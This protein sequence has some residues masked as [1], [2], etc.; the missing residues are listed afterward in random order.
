MNINFFPPLQLIAFARIAQGILYTFDLEFLKRNFMLGG[1]VYPVYTQRIQQKVSVIVLRHYLIRFLQPSGTPGKIDQVKH[2]NLP[3][4]MQKQLVGIVSALGFEIVNWFEF[5]KGIMLQADHD[6]RN[7]LSWFS[8]GIIDRFETARNFILD[9]K[10]SVF[11]RFHLACKYYFEDYAPL[12]F[13]RIPTE[14][15]SSFLGRLSDT[16][17][18]EL[19]SVVL[20]RHA[21]LDWG[22]ISRYERRHFFRDNFLGIRYYFKRL[23]GLE[24]RCQCLFFALGNEELHPL[25]LYLCLSQM[26]ANEL[27]SLLSRLP[28]RALFDL[29][30]YF[31]CWPFQII[32]MNVVNNFKH[33][34]DRNTFRNLV[35]SILYKLQKGWYDYRYVNLFESLWSLMSVRYGRFF[36]EDEELK[37]VADFALANFV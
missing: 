5:H 31:L 28:D 3:K 2:L 27:N 29:F 23:Q 1:L 36:T 33:H 14:S 20:N 24:T 13:E 22:Q 4:E 9:E 21:A 16:R 11:Y 25:D 19:W 35:I 7:K 26:T 34:I 32:F 18:M 37:E 8:F 10:L 15:R 30:H 6:L 12:L 17:S